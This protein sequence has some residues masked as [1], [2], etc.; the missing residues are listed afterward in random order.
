M[1]NPYLVQHV[2]GVPLTEWLYP[3]SIPY[4]KVAEKMGRA[5]T[6]IDVPM[7]GGK[8]PMALWG[9][10]H[11][12]AQCSSPLV[13]VSCPQ[14]PIEQWR[15]WTETILVNPCHIMQGKTTDTE[16]LGNYLKKVT[17]PVVVLPHAILQYHTE[18]ILSLAE[19]YQILT[20]WDEV[21]ELSGHSI[22]EK[23]LPGRGLNGSQWDYKRTKKGAIVKAAQLYRVA[24]ASRWRVGLT[25]TLIRKN[26][27][28][29][30]GMLNN[31]HPGEHGSYSKWTAY[32]CGGHQ[33]ED[34]WWVANRKT[35][36][37]ELKRNLKK[38]AYHVPKSEV[39]KYRPKMIVQRRTVSVAEQPATIRAT[40][41]KERAEAESTK[42]GRQEL[43]L[44]RAALLCRLVANSL[45]K[46]AVA[47]GKK[48][49]LWGGRYKWL[50]QR[51]KLFS[52][53]YKKYRVLKHSGEQTM[54]ER[55]AALKEF[56]RTPSHIMI[57]CTYQSA[58]TGVNELDTD[59][60]IVEQMPTTPSLFA[61]MIYRHGRNGHTHTPHTLVLVAEESYAE[62]QADRVFERLQ[63]LGELADNDVAKDAA[64]VMSDADKDEERIS[65]L[66]SLINGGPLG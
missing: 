5:G 1:S 53:R 46:D 22:W 25:G 35:N 26:R 14:G 20:I 9:I 23:V 21:H 2:N 60:A 33:N 45:V 31:V 47:E 54:A 19:R 63:D 24:K 44:H 62:V 51:F 3:Y 58:G 55:V 16:A 8:T 41:K 11:A 4:A 15:H 49:V 18:H 43:M 42:D 28:S 52:N 32:Y 48:I 12:A 30:W 66:L 57:I 10:A 7:G 56:E 36:T 17:L 65:E 13:L 40:T 27:S 38:W 29:M 50:E 59:I 61:Q 34:G 6:L 37:A 64:A 39:D